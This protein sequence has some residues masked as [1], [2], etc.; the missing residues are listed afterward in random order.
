MKHGARERSQAARPTHGTRSAS[1]D[2]LAVRDEARRPRGE[3][4]EFS[5][6]GVGIGRS[7]GAGEGEKPGDIPGK[8]IHA[9]GDPGHPTI[10]DD[11]HGIACT[12]LGVTLT[13][14]V[15]A[16]WKGAC[17]H[18]RTTKEQHKQG[19]SCQ[20][21]PV[22]HECAQDCRRRCAWKRER[23][24]SKGQRGDDQIRGPIQKETS[25]C[26]GFLSTR[27]WI[28]GRQPVD[29]RPAPVQSKFKPRGA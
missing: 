19:G 13:G 27:L 25:S 12:A 8:C 9:Q 18:A 20:S 22:E 23:T 11:L 1:R 2:A 21:T 29:K 15:L 7:Q 4:A 16:A 28:T 26:C 5:G 14:I 3:W 17:Q 10:G 24:Q 6:P